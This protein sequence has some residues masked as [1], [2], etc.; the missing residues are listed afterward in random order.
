YHVKLDNWLTGEG[1]LGNQDNQLQG[2]DII[3]VPS[4]IVS[5]P[6]SVCAGSGNQNYTAVVTN[7]NNPVYVWSI[8]NSNQT[9]PASI[10]SGQGQVA[11]P[12]VVNPGSTGS[13][14]VQLVVTNDGGTGIS[15]TCSQSTTVTCP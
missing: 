7:P 11:N 5:G 15:S 4:C 9:T 13:Y 8:I 10:V 12:L 1:N 14:T 2:A 6:G 3:L